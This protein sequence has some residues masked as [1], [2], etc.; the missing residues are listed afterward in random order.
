MCSLVTFFICKVS[1][2]VMVKFYQNPD[3]CWKVRSAQISPI[4]QPGHSPIVVTH[5]PLTIWS[6]GM[7]IGKRRELPSEMVFGNL[8]V[9]VLPKLPNFV[10]SNY[11]TVQF[12]FEQFGRHAKFCIFLTVS[13]L[14]LYK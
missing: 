6:R 14:R 2:E 8:G 13:P 10:S 1:G 12:R 7:N 5:N 9:L 3:L 11:C 4:Q